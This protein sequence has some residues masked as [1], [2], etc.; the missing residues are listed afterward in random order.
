MNAKEIRVGDLMNRDI[1]TISKT[2]GL[3]AVVER[4]RN[5]DIFQILKER[6]QLQFLRPKSIAAAYL[7]LCSFT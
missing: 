7:V 1:K 4:M 5:L 3:M 6:C 2:T